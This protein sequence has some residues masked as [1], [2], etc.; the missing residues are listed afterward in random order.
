M[1]ALRQCGEALQEEGYFGKA[2]A[3]WAKPLERDAALKERVVTAALDAQ[4]GTKDYFAQVLSWCADFMLGDK[5]RFGRLCALVSGAA[6]G[7]AQK[8]DFG[9]FIH[10]ASK[11]GNP[12]AFRQAAALAEKI[13]PRERKG[14]RYPERDFGGTVVSADAMLSTSSTCSDDAPSSYPF[15]TDALPWDG[16][17]FLVDW[18]SSP[19]AM[20]TLA[21]ECRVRGVL[22]VNR[23]PNVGRR[24]RQVPIEIQ[25]SADGKEW[26][27][28]LSDDKVRDEYRADLG[29]KPAVAKYVRVRRVPG[30]KKDYFHLNKIIVYGD[31][32]Y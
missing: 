8:I 21:G 18:E 9:G 5:G 3:R 24:R 23:N 15:A 13:S 30:A 32:L 29:E 28:V 19:W 31:K 16:N 27:T 25:V 22:V 4:R 10:A 7:N 14:K 20:V 17:A 11:S 12:A 1:P 2:L 6:G 26:N